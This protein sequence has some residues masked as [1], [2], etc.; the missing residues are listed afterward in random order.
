MGAIFSAI[1]PFLVKQKAG[2]EKKNIVSGVQV[3]GG[4][5]QQFAVRQMQEKGVEVRWV[6]DPKDLEEWSSKIDEDTRFLYVE[7]PSN[8]QQTFCDV[9]AVADLA[10]SWEIPFIFDATCATPALL[11]PIEFGADIVVHSLTKRVI[12]IHYGT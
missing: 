11:R 10:H 7:A 4:T 2:E 9:Q 8:P 3:Y 6:L 12:P 5:Y 1:E